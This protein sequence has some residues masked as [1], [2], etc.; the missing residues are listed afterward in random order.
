VTEAT[1]QQLERYCEEVLQQAHQ[2]F[3]ERFELS[4]YITNPFKLINCLLID[5]FL[6][7]DT[8]D[9]FIQPTLPSQIQNIYQ[10]LLLILSAYIFKENISQDTIVYL[11]G[12]TTWL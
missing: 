5:T 3:D 2:H 11:P 12:D 4:S 1:K 10:P 8:H 7:Q 6:S 9:L